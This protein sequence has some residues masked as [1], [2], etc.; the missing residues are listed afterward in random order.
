MAAWT[1][2]AVRAA[3]EDLNSRDPA[4]VRSV[5]LSTFTAGNA[6][7]IESMMHLLDQAMKLSPVLLPIIRSVLG[8]TSV[9]ATCQP[10]VAHWAQL[11]LVPLP[12]APP[13]HGYFYWTK[14][15]R[16]TAAAA[17]P[18]PPQPPIVA[19]IGIERTA[20][21]HCNEPF[22]LVFSDVLNNWALMG[23][24]THGGRIWHVDCTPEAVEKWAL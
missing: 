21:A 19:A 3:A 13:A 20:C 17:N 6:R 22:S 9:P 5:L 7:A 23:A 10:I 11:R 4:H 12:T 24:A 15:T 14:M 1:R 16:L 8:G 2:A 18:A